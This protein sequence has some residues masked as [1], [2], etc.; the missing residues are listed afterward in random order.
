M[1]I[2]LLTERYPGMRA[3]LTQRLTGLVMAIY[4]IVALLRFFIIQPENYEAWVSFS[5]PIWWRI[6]SLIFWLALSM[7]AWLG[8]RDVFK[9]YVPNYVV[10]RVLQN[11]LVVLLWIYLAWALW[12]LLV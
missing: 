12:L 2:E 11:I 8:I 4:S 6:A 5:Q 10:Q 9:D 7:H 3:W 1:L